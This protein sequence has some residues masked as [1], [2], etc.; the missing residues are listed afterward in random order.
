MNADEKIY[1][2][3]YVAE[4]TE[5]VYDK[6]EV[7]KTCAMWDSNDLP[8]KGG[9]DTVSDAIAAVCGANFFTNNRKWWTNWAQDF[10]DDESGRFSCSWLVD[11]ENSEA[12]EADIAMWKRGEKRL[13]VCDINVYLEVRSTRKLTA[14][15]CAA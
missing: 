8:V 15:E 12:D 3:Y 7:G 1:V 6:G 4:T 10:G 14:A 9:F 13:W 2:R 11:N 5:D